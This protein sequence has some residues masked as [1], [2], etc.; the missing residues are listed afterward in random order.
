MGANKEKREGQGDTQAPH[1]EAGWEAPT[2]K[3]FHRP[4]SKAHP[5][6]FSFFDY[7]MLPRSKKSRRAPFS[8]IALCK[9]FFHT[10][11]AVRQP[12]FLL[13]EQGRFYGKIC[14]NLK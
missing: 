5:Y 1:R 2:R 11:V 12:I 13:V 4:K 9:T 14:R 8:S 6:L 7:Y 3:E 10:S